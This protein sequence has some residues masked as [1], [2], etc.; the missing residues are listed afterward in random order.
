MLQQY[1]VIRQIQPF[2]ELDSH[3]IN[4]HHYE[5]RSVYFDSPFKKS[6]FEKTN[7]IKTRIKL[8]IRYY[9]DFQNGDEE[10]VFIELKKKK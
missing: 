5:V 4:D 10:L 2:M 1:N 7:G 9:P 8:R 3:V 6:F